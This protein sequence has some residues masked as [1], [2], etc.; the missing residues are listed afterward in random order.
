MRRLASML[1]LAAPVFA[2]GVVPALAQDRPPTIPTRDVDVTYRMVQPIEGGPA[3]MQRMRWSVATGRLRVDPPS[4][5]LYMIVDYRARRMAVVHPADRAVV[6]MTTSGP[7]LP[8]SSAG[9]FTRL[10]IGHVAGTAC[11]NWQTR[12]TNGQVVTVCITAEGVM[13]RASQGD[14]V[15]LEAA[16]VNYDTQDPGAFLPPDGYR[17]IEQGSP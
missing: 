5:A 7:G 16:S 17:H 1:L 13:L 11:S 14:N 12:D 8:G 6:D 10:D 4:P 15:L 9:G 2:P 3:L